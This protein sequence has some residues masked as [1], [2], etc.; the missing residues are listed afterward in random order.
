M[1]VFIIQV[2]SIT[3]DQGNSIYFSES[4][5]LLTSSAKVFSSIQLSSLPQQFQTDY[6]ELPSGPI[7]TN[8]V[9]HSVIKRNL[10]QLQFIYWRQTHISIDHESTKIERLMQ[11]FLYDLAIGWQTT[12]RTH[13]RY[14]GLGIMLFRLIKDFS[15]LQPCHLT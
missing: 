6:I 2:Q 9:E 13:R 15:V 7:Y 11:C 12:S 3:R 10:K 8:E 5:T 1:N 14:N 4:G